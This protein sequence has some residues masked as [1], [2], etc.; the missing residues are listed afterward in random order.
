MAVT[1]TAEL[2]RRCQLPE[3]APLLTRAGFDYVTD[4]AGIERSELVRIGV[5]LGHA[6]RLLREVRTEVEGTSG[7]HD[8]AA[9]PLAGAWLAPPPPEGAAPLPPPGHAAPAAHGAP[10]APPPQ[11]S[12]RRG[13][14]ILRRG[15]RVEALWDG[16]WLPASVVDPD[17]VDGGVEVRWASDQTHT[18]VR[19][20][21]VRARRILRS[22]SM[23]GLPLRNSER[24]AQVVSPATSARTP[25]EV[26][27]PASGTSAASEGASPV[28]SPVQAP[29][30]AAAPPRLSGGGGARR[31]QRRHEPSPPNPRAA[32]P[33]PP[34]AA[35]PAAAPAAPAPAPPR[36]SGGAPPPAAPLSPPAQARGT[37]VGPRRRRSSLSGGHKPPLRNPRR[38]S[39]RLRPTAKGSG[40]ARSRSAGSVDSGGAGCASAQGSES[41]ALRR[42]YSAQLLLYDIGEDELVLF[43]GSAERAVTLE[44]GTHP[45]TGAACSKIVVSGGSGGAVLATAWAPDKVRAGPG[46]ETVSWHGPVARTPGEM[47]DEPIG[48]RF[49]C[50]QQAAQFCS[51]V[52]VHGRD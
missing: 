33:P 26:A 20:E 45:N 50:R 52:A 8:P 6:N 10:A 43:D 27:T 1:T 41:P 38:A 3:L 13:G 42:Q 30:L 22:R 35:A 24:R 36:W 32:P 34:P 29:E 21:Q 11:G 14:G 9:A 40:A 17:K 31:T 44:P 19:P 46:A 39:D 49:S 15:N 37:A 7:P 23:P 48:L 5:K 12:P 47:V 25:S 4:L 2:L 16:E 28:V 51:A 18:L